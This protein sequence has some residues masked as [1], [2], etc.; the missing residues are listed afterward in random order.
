TWFF[1]RSANIGSETFNYVH[2]IILEMSFAG[3][4][5]SWR[6]LDNTGLERSRI[7]SVNKCGDKVFATTLDGVFYKHWSNFKTL[8]RSP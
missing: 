7:T 6:S 8:R 1:M 2:D 3:N 5:L 4:T